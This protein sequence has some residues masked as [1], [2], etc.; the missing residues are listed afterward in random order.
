MF[1]SLLQM[2]AL[3]LCGVVWRYARPGGLD[4]VSTRTALTGLVYYLLLPALV[5]M[6]L[7]QAPLG[8][9]SF[10]IAFVASVSI[11]VSLVL[12]H[13]LCNACD[14]D[15]PTRGAAILAAA[16][17]NATYLGLPVLEATLGDASRS[18]VIQYDL[19]ANT[20]LLLTIGVWIA[21]RNGNQGQKNLNFNDLLKIPAL[22]AATLAV[23]L[24]LSDVPMPGGIKTW[25]QTLANGVIPLMLISL[26]LS[27]Y[28]KQEHLKQMRSIIPVLGVK[29]FFMPVVA[30]VLA[31]ALGMQGMVKQVVI[32]E[33]A[34]PSMVIGIMLCDRYGLNSVVYAASVTVSTALSFITLGIWF[35]LVQT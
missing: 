4:A 32:L 27:L 16:F 22:W 25:L 33:A 12:M 15:R 8:T 13:G 10:K 1:D 35:G 2:G 6:V 7:W 3:I 5:L 18:M 9:D 31:T 23:V 26:G 19:F 20:P 34:M 29:L 24:N 21:M 14:M 28:I 30:M 11:L 17:P